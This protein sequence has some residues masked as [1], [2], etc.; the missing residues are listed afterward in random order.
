MEREKRER[1]RERERERGESKNFEFIS[2]YIKLL[3][4]E[5]R[6]DD[7]MFSLVNG[8]QFA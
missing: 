2:I 8:V 6:K 7:A 5:E 4:F 1:E 3:I